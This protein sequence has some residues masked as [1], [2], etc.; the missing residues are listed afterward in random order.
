MAVVKRL[1]NHARQI[2]TVLVRRDNLFKR[3]TAQDGVLTEKSAEILESSQIA[4]EELR[5]QTY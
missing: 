2:G 4:L 1:R 3:S 5:T